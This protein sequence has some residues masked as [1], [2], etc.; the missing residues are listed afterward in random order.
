MKTVEKDAG[1][2]I[3]KTVSVVVPAY[4]EVETV[5]RVIDG[6]LSMGLFREIVVINDGSTD[7]T[8]EILEGYR[9]RIISINNPKN[10]G[11]EIGRAHV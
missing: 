6:L 5:G 10:S 4:N 9:D 11:K 2:E 1:E 7:G 8:K 3:P